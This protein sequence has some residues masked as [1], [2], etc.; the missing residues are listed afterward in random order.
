MRIRSSQSGRTVR[1]RIGSAP[2]WVVALILSFVIVVAGLFIHMSLFKGESPPNTPAGCL[3]EDTKNETSITFMV[4]AIS[5]NLPIG[6][7]KALLAT[8]GMAYGPPANLTLE[9]ALIENGGDCLQLQFIDNGEKGRLEA[10]DVFSSTTET[11]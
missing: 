2:A 11:G 10:G 5:R 7:V 9:G 1:K 6:D 3:I 8:K 4:S